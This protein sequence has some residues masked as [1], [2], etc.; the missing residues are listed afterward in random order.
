QNETAGIALLVARLLEGDFRLNRPNFRPAVT[1][2]LLNAGLPVDTLR[3]VFARPQD[4]IPAVLND[5]ITF[6]LWASDLQPLNAQY[7][8]LANLL[9]RR[10]GEDQIVTFSL[11]IRDATGWK[12][13]YFS[14][15]GRRYTPGAQTPGILTA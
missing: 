15:D 8:F 14:V 6:G 11:D 1:A 3:S 12:I 13:G 10:M 9:T 7:I 5:P 2:L 4:Y